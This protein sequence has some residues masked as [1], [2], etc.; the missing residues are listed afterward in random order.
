[1]AASLVTGERASLLELADPVV[2][3]QGGPAHV[4]RELL[5]GVEGRHEPPR[6]LRSGAVK[7]MHR[8]LPLR[9]GR[10]ASI[11]T[12]D[13]LTCRSRSSRGLPAGPRNAR[14]YRTGAWPA[15]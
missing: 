2:L 14:E 15:S 5:L 6:H 8:V 4:G 3:G 9:R 13:V 1:M 11:D 10:A 7:V 12:P